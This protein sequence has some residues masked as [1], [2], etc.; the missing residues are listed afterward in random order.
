MVRTR[1]VARRTS[2]PK[3]LTRSFLMAGGRSEA[4]KTCCLAAN[5]APCVKREFFVNAPLRSSARWSM[6]AGDTRF[7]FW[8]VRR[9]PFRQ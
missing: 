6:Y 1:L 8:Y 5:R 4:S 9:H 7:F 2:R 3:A